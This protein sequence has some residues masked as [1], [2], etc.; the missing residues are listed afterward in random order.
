MIVIVGLGNPGKQYEYTRHNIGF[1]IV[2]ALADKYNISINKN[3][4][5]AL[6]GEGKIG[7]QKV[8]FVKPLTYMNLSGESIREIVDFYKILPEDLIVVYDDI[9]LPL[10]NLRIRVKGSAG[11]HNG[12]KSLIQHL[13]TEQF[14]RL[15]VGIGGPRP[16]QNL[17]DFVLERFSKEEQ[18]ILNTAVIDKSVSALET[19]ILEDIHQAMNQFNG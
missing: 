10:G 13:K 5:K 2:D 19:W 14:P 8:L 17:A 18:T 6:I 15:K 3:K 9:S 11:G 16:H 7:S 4:H 12:I 1:N